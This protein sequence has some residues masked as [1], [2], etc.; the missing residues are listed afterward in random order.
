MFLAA[1]FATIL[2]QQRLVDQVSGDRLL[3]T[4]KGLASFQNRNTNFDG[5][6]EAC[7]WAAERLRMVPGLQVEI[8]KYTATGN[9]VP[10]TKEVVQVVAVLPGKTDRRIL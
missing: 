2:G 5:L 1:A 9:R 4:V 6:T 3:D 10:V 7:N 8:M